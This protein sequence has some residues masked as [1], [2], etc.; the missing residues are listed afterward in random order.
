MGVGELVE[1]PRLARSGLANDGDHL[2]AT[3]SRLA[4]YS[5]KVLDLGIATDEARE[6]THRRHLEPCSRRSCPGQ[7]EDL[8]RVCEALHWDG[9]ERL[10]LH[11]PLGEP[12]AIR[13]ETDRPGSGQLLH[14]GREMRGLAHRGV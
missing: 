6:T 9:P 4:Q 11:V 3:G 8:D 1:Q 12:C 13:G 7:L 10:H 2:S 5:P 14:P